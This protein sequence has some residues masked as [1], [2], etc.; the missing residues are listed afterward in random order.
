[1]KKGIHMPSDAFFT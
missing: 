1:V